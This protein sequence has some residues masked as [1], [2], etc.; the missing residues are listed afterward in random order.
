MYGG[1]GGYYQSRK[2]WITLKDY[3]IIAFIHGDS[4]LCGTFFEDK[5]VILPEQ[6]TEYNYDLVIL[7]VDKEK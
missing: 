6:V 2:D 7:A 5:R 3:N 4:E 1:W